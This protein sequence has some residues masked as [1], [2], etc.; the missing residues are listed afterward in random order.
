MS[1]LRTSLTEL[2]VMIEHAIAERDE[3]LASLAEKQRA[4]D[5]AL[6]HAP[7]GGIMVPFLR[8]HATKATEG[9]R[10]TA[11]HYTP[12]EIEA[13]VDAICARVKEANSSATVTGSPAPADDTREMVAREMLPHLYNQM[14]DGFNR[15]QFG[16]SEDWVEGLVGDAF[17][18]A[19]VFIAAARRGGGA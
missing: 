4:I 7:H 6:A 12:A 15:G 13:N 9:Q 14:C 5:Q 8:P 10:S 2:G 1:D 19:D 18:V 3:A 11:A 16:W 17:K